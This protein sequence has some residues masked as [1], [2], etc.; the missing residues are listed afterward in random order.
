VHIEFKNP[1]CKKLLNLRHTNPQA[2]S[3]SDQVAS[4]FTQ[5]Q[6]L[7]EKYNKHIK[8][9]TDGSKKDEKIKCALET[10]D[11]KLRKRLKSQKCSTVLNKKQ[12]S[13][14]YPLPNGQ[15]NGE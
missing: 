15:V 9:Y 14:Q 8:I 11:Q 5:K 12:L 13:K 7:E 4:D 2:Q 1:K 6:I 10:P 3:Q